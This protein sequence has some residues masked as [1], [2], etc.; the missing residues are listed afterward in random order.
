MKSFVKIFACALS[1]SLLCFLSSC[2]KDDP[3]A[4]CN[5]QGYFSVKINGIDWVSTSFNNTLV[6]GSVG[7][8]GG[9]RMDIRAIDK[10]GNTLYLSFTDL[11][12]GTLGDCVAPDADYIPFEDVVT[13]DENVYTVTYI[14]SNNITQAI[15]IDGTLDITECNETNK[16]VSGTFTFS[17]TDNNADPFAGTEGTFTD[18]CY[19]VLR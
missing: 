5:G 10:D 11:T 13:G 3:D 6:V 7:G 17:G 15:L 8:V 2:D 1:L 14:D 12:T 9:K 19:K 4:G 18:V 16:T